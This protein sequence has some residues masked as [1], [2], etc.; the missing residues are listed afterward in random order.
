MCVTHL[1]TL[2]A[3]QFNVALVLYSA[4]YNELQWLVVHVVHLYKR[5]KISPNLC[6]LQTFDSLSYCNVPQCSPLHK[7]SKR[8]PQLLIQ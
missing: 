7:S 5:T 4:G 2:V 1:V 6:T 8:L 3:D